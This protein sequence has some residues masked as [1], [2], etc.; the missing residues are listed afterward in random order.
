MASLSDFPSLKAFFARH[1]KEG[2]Y[3]LQ[4]RKCKDLTCC[5]RKTNLPPEIPAPVLSP[6]GEKY[7]KFEDLYRRVE[8]TEKDCPSLSKLNSKKKEQGPRYKMLASRVAA[9]I[10]CHQCGKVRCVFSLN[11]SLTPKGQREIEDTIF[12][13]GMALTSNIYT[14]M[15]LVCSSPIENAIYTSRSTNNYICYHCGGTQ[16][17][18]ISFKKKIKEFK[19]VYP[20]C[21]ACKSDGKKE[22]CA[23]PLSKK[24]SSVP[25]QEQQARRS[26]V[27]AD[28]MRNEETAT[29]P[30]SDA[31]KTVTADAASAT[32]DTATITTADA[33]T[34]TAASNAATIVTASKRA[35]TSKAD[36]IDMTISSQ[37]KKSR[38]IKGWLKQ[39][40][41]ECVICN[42]EDPPNARAVKVSW[43]DFDLCHRW[44]HTLCASKPGKWLHNYRNSWLCELHKNQS[45]I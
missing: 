12:T 41:D 18:V 45:H 44:A 42:Q 11:G 23:I 14:S 22:Y 27:E 26:T 8:T 10:L 6:D 5:E 29:T 33:V 20:I 3:M 31:D 21:N 40:D 13:C 32:P 15:H 39:S 17:N 35:S 30:S 7:L 1:V 24:K 28:A 2:L 4:F 34:I 9:T 37:T 19:T 16:I 43:I 25:L 36:D 38:G